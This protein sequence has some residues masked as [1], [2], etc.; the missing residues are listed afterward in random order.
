M[1][2][3]KKIIGLLMTFSIITAVFGCIYATGVFDSMANPFVSGSAGYSSTLRSAAGRVWF[4]VRLV[5]QYLAVGI[6]IYSGI[7]YMV[8]SAEQKADIKKSLGH[9]SIGAAITFASITIIDV[10]IAIAKELI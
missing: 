9:L 6:I 4:I 5:L 3:T 1:G 7:R 10:I 2:K 8:A